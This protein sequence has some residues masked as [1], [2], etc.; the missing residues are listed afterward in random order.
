MSRQEDFSI[1]T[2]SRLTGISQHTLR[3]WERRY[4]AVESRRSEGGRR[5]YSSDDVE[6]L[7]ML[8][9]LVDRGDRI[10][11]IAN[12]DDET[13]RE[14]LS[15]LQDHTEARSQLATGVVELAVVGETLAGLLRDSPPAG[16]NVVLAESDPERFEADVALTS[17]DALIVELA[18]IDQDSP[19]KIAAL[20]RAARTD[21]V[22]VVYG[23]GRS[24]DVERLVKGG[25]Q[26]LRAPAEPHA[27]AG[28]IGLEAG[29]ERHGPREKPAAMA[30]APPPGSTAPPRRLTP[31]SLQRLARTSTTVECECPHHLVDLVRSLSAFEIYSRQCRNRNEDDA[32][33]H[34]YLHLTTAR[35]RA[36]ME[37]ALIRTAEAEGI[38]Y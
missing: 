35:A 23:F 27:I 2:V 10:G 36:M 33:L 12:E 38:E 24:A 3:V 14:R 22:V 17:A 7:T 31:Q 8:K 20:Q 19:E 21:R 6:R 4:G 9:A 32:A 30:P 37:E 25:V 15:V 26:V 11:Q 5:L 13:L 29:P 34:A 28:L 16:A 1:G 18:C